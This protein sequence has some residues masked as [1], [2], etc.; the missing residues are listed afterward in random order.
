MKRFEWALASRYFRGRRKESRFLSF[1]KLMAIAGV[2]IGAAGLLISLSIVH[3][4]KST[5]NEKVVGFAP[6]ITIQTLTSEPI[7]RADTLR[8]HIEKINGVE[9]VLPAVIGEVMLQSRID[10]S[11]AILKG[12]PGG[13]DITALEQYLEMGEFNTAPDS[14][15]RPGIILGRRLAEQI[16]AEP[17][18]TVTAFRIEGVPTPFNTP[19]LVQFHLS[20]IY[21]TGID[22]FDE[23]FALTEITPVRGLYHLGQLQATS[24]DIRI[25]NP[26]RASIERI[27]N[28]LATTL[29]YPFTVETIYQRYRN[30][31]AWI[32]LQEQTI[33]FVISVMIIIAAFNLI[34]TVLMMVLERVRD[35]GILKTMGTRSGAIRRIFLL[36]G[37]FVAT[38]GLIIGIGIALLFNWIQSTWQLIPLAEEN[39]YMSYAPVEPHATDFLMVIAVT[40]LLCAL[41]SWIPARFAAKTDP[42]SVLSFGR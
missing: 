29:E 11:G 18:G 8:T 23:G 10:I 1:I 36:E 15:G 24:L 19:D 37:M 2:A 34:G 9:R 28:E 25:L 6:H 21:E 41:A 3:G 31:F 26:D 4:F 38:T 14:A 5:I 12:V 7:F 30:I 16:G 35:I 40:Y 33:P 22:R 17:G 27:Y 13:E 39:Y 20:G 32:D 42:V